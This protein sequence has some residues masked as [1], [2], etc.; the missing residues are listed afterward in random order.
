MRVISLFSGA[1]GMDL[2][3][4]KAGHTVVWANDHDTD[5]VRTYRHNIGVDL[6]MFVEKRALEWRWDFI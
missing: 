5:C 2:G 4:V 6:P 3:F 1:G